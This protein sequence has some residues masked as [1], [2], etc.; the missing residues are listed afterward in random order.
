[1]LFLF[2]EIRCL[3]PII[4]PL[5]YSVLCGEQTLQGQKSLRYS[6]DINIEEQQNSYEWCLLL[7]SS[8]AIISLFFKVY[9]N[10]GSRNV[11]S[12]EAFD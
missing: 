8:V 1:M 6:N 9:E 12:A 4:S 11:L 10:E 7:I 3:Y 5:F 2:R